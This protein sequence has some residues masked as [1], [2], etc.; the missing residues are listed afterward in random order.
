MVIYLDQ[1]YFCHGWLF[2]Q[3]YRFIASFRV[4]QFIH[5][6]RRNI[7]IRSQSGCRQ[8][9]PVTVSFGNRRHNSRKE[10]LKLYF[11]FQS[12]P[13]MHCERFEH[14]SNLGLLCGHLGAGRP[15]PQ[16]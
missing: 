6:L 10:K 13:P 9:F 8:H 2:A 12:R 1:N 3:N 5:F 15:G 4:A 11:D 7:S 16:R 14:G